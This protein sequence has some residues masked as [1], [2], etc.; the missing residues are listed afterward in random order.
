M[1]KKNKKTLILSVIICLLPMV[2]GIAFTPSGSST[3][4]NSEHRA[5]VRSF[6]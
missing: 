3:L 2:L 6:M 4:S 1:E 5:N